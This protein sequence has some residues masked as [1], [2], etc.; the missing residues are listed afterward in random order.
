MNIYLLTLSH[1]M[2]NFILFNLKSLI[3]IIIIGMYFF[4]YLIH[5]LIFE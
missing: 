5:N 3:K 1:Y 4:F 2:V